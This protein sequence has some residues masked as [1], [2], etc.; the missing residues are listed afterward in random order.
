MKCETYCTA[1][2]YNIVALRRDLRESYE[3]TLYKDVLHIEVPHF[4][5]VSH[6]FYFPYGVTVCWGL[7]V[8]E[9][10]AFLEEAAKV[11]EEPLEKPEKDEYLFTIGEQ[12]RIIKNE[13]FLPAADTLSLIALSHGLAQSVK[14]EAFESA[15]QTTYNNSKHM[16]TAFTPRREAFRSQEEKSAG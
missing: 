11:A 13:I 4:S 1:A 16:P 15:V 3:S 9:V 2:S 5:T 8:D 6:V 14:L 12:A 7:D 10:R